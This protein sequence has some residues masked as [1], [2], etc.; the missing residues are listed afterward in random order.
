MEGWKGQCVAGWG[1]VAENGRGR[2]GVNF[3]VF[4]QDFFSRQVS[5]GAL[6]L[7]G[8]QECSADRGL[9]GPIVVRKENGQV[10]APRSL[11]G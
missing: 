10:T 11:S 3:L 1:G 6:D 8:A 5:R 2:H 7:V 9:Y 4:L